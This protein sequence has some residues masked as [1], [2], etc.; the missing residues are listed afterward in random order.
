MAAAVALSADCILENVDRLP[1]QIQL[2]HAGKVAISDVPY[3]PDN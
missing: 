3:A 2:L 1:P